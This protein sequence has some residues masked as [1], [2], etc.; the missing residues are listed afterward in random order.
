M[1]PYI[2][3]MPLYFQFDWLSTR[4]VLYLRGPTILSIKT[5]SLFGILFKKK[6]KI[7]QC[8]F[9]HYF[10]VYFYWHPV[11]QLETII[12]FTSLLHLASIINILKGIIC[13]HPEESALC[14]YNFSNMAIFWQNYICTH[15]TKAHAK[16]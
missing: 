4:F 15:K 3:N 12:C 6:K 13:N 2:L 14:W 5:G 16:F 7:S 1:F 9:N 8:L 10:D 11:H